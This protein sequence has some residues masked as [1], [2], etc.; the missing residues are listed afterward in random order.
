MRVNVEKEDT[1]Q[2][3]IL[4]MGRGSAEMATFQLRKQNQEREREG[5]KDLE[6]IRNVFLIFSDFLMPSLKIKSQNVNIDLK[7]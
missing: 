2:C 7:G 5:D 3:I 4:N 1:Y 6:V